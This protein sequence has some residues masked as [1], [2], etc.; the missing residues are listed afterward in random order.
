MAFEDFSADDYD[1]F[2][3][4]FSRPLAR[5]FADAVLPAGAARVLDVG[6]GPGALLDA[7]GERGPRGGSAGI[8]PAEQF[9]AAARRRHPWA[10]VRSG[11]AEALPFEDGAFDA[12]LAALVVHFLPDAPA[13]V[14]EMV[15][16]TRRGGTVA[17][18]VWDLQNHRAPHSTYLRAVAEIAPRPPR[19]PR[20]GTRRGDLATLM[21]DAGCTAVE[22]GELTV[23]SGYA[24]FDEWWRVHALGMGSSA[25]VLNGLDAATTDAV[26]RRCRE[27]IGEGPITTTATAWWARGTA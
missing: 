25:G 21:T 3:G 22:E 6:C 5:L 23:T 4:R 27:L 13:G 20:P 11:S 24:D 15:R 7:L 1:A 14:R 17:A 26:R 2:M 18:S 12:T 9:V 10:D 19:P 8:D 16:V